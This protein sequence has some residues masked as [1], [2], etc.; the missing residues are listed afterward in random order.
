MS[1]PYDDDAQ[2]EG[3]EK[4]Q[5]VE[6]VAPASMKDLR[7]CM[8]CKLVQTGKQFMEEGCPNCHLI[9]YK[10]DRDKVQNCTT[11]NYSGLISL[12][13]PKQSWVARYNKLTEHVPGCYAVHV[14]GDLPEAVQDDLRMQH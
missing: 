1:S 2:H 14:S 7:A 11:T 6:G 8:N 10:G 12:M 5:E 3:G 9:D 4:E 13:Q